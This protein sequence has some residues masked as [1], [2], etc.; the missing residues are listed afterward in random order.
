MA[1]VMRADPAKYGGSVE[2]AAAFDRVL[3][4]LDKGLMAGATLRA[5]LDQPFDAVAALD[6]SP[7]TREAMRV[8]LLDNVDFLLG[9]LGTEAETNE[10]QLLVGQFAVYA[11]Y[12]VLGSKFAPDPKLFERM[13]RVAERLP[14]V[15]LYTK[16]RWLPDAFLLEYCAVP[17][18]DMRKLVPRVRAG[19]ARAALE[20]GAPAAPPADM[21]AAPTCPPLQ[22]PRR[23]PR[24]CA[25]RRRRS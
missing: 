11:L 12:R 25:R 18:L 1:D 6:A 22:Q 19:V 23:T 20:P 7:A 24:R 4:A 10:A 2:S 8:R 3:L 5:C 14:M 17:G 9:S 16:Y 15:V 13:W 21:P